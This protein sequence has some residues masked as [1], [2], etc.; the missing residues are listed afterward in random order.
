[1]TFL[2]KLL[3][4]SRIS[5]HLTW[6]IYKT[7]GNRR[8][9]VSMKSVKLSLSFC[10]VVYFLFGGVCQAAWWVPILACDHGAARIEV[11]LGER[12]KVRI[13]IT[14]KDVREYL[15]KSGVTF[16]SPHFRNGEAIGTELKEGIFNSSDFRGFNR[17]GVSPT[18]HSGFAPSIKVYREGNGLKLVA[19]QEYGSPCCY[20]TNS[21]TGHCYE[22]GPEI[23]KLELANWY[24]RSCEEISLPNFR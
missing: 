21:S 8:K 3:R 13:V 5:R 6:S 4:F 24:F 15:Y 22:W 19:I 7:S 11:D 17:K 16:F 2:P 10:F 20:E 18:C 9:F 14:N 23:P 12:R 1:M